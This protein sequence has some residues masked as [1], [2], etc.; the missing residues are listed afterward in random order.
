MHF[1]DDCVVR[2]DDSGLGVQG[3]F[4]LAWE[5]GGWCYL[6]VLVILWW[7][8]VVGE[9]WMVVDGWLLK[10]LGVWVGGVDVLGLHL[11][12]WW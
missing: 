10:L 12:R 11:R 5:I 4:V 1:G 2:L 3:G 6:R 7:R 8:L 9:S